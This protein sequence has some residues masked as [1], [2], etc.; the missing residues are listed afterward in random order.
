MFAQKLR[1]RFI[2]RLRSLG[3][4]A[5]RDVD[6]EAQRFVSALFRG[7]LRR[8]PDPTGLHRFCEALRSGRTH[9]TVVEDFLN[10]EEFRN[11][12]R[13]R[14]FVPPGHYF[15]P[16]VDPGEAAYHIDSRAQHV[17]EFLPGIFI[18]KVDMIRTWHALLPFLNTCP[19]PDEQDVNFR[20]A[21]INP[22]YAFGDGSILHA[23]LRLRRPKRLIEIGSGWSSA[24]T[25]DTVE[26]YLDSCELTFIEPYPDV[27]RERLGRG[28]AKVRLIEKPVQ[29]VQPN[30]FDELQAADILF[31]D[32]THVLRTGSDVCFELFEI[33][34]RLAPGVLVHFHDI[35]WPF[36]YPRSWSVDEN[37]SWNELYALRAYLMNNQSWRIMFFNDYFAQQER[38]LVESTYSKFLRNP[39]G[40][41]WLERL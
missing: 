4:L 29:R 31:I 40:A 25:F 19:F 36:E 11:Q 26:R 39:G 23:M 14:L 21:F 13:A 8:E 9:L 38:A 12:L 1:Y 27:L 7:F 18:D 17:V 35:F 24:C 32:S 16:I 34:P 33:L 2:D 15:S 6:D 5:P 37:R 20:Y 28:L 41:L 22:A 3:V 30:L 10:S